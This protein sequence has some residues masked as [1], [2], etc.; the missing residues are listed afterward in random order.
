MVV[1]F[2]VFAAPPQTKLTI[3]NAGNMQVTVV[4]DGNTY[5]SNSRSNYDE[6]DIV[7]N[8]LRA[9][10]HNVKVYQQI[11][12]RG[13]GNNRNQ[14]L[15]YDANVYVKQQYHV[16]ITINRFGK[17]FV[18]EQQL[19][20]TYDDNNYGNNNG[21]GYGNGNNNGWG[22]SNGGYNANGQVMNARS[23]EQLKQAMRSESFEETRTTMAKQNI[24]ANLFSASQVKELVMLFNFEAN[25]LEV[26]KYAY[27]YTTDKANYYIINEALSFTSSREELARF[28]QQRR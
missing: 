23:F 19:A 18:D 24:A 28:I 27:A 11:A 1:S 2:S 25:K 14:R 26:A 5:S 13:R 15:L 21:N 12:S 20:R 8:D 10:Y 9:G 22:N 16:D 4:V 3:N 7:I 17:A 6:D